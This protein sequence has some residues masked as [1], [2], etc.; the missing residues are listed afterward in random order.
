MDFSV[1]GPLVRG[2]STIPAAIVTVEEHRTQGRVESAV[3][4]T[5]VDFGIS[6]LTARV[7]AERGDG[8]DEVAY[9]LASMRH[10]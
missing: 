6:C 8:G 1:I 2:Q 7:G 9:V 3:A 5:L 10:S 4:D